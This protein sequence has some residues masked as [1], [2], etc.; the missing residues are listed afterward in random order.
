MSARGPQLFIIGASLSKQQQISVADQAI[1]KALSEIAQK[2]VRDSEL[3]RVQAQIISSQ[4]YKRDSVFAQAME[5][6]MTEIVGI[7]W[8]EKDQILERLQ[9]V[10]SLDIQRVIQKYFIDDALTVAVLDPQPLAQSSQPRATI[11]GGRH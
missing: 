7:S 10:K 6:G 9:R 11:P 5:I 4:I 1:R 3:K 8:R 2:G